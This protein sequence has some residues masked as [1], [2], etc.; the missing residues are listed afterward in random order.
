MIGY[1]PLGIT[2]TLLLAMLLAS[3]Y[4][5]IGLK[6]QDGQI[7]C[8][9]EVRSRSIIPRHDFAPPLSSTRVP[10]LLHSPVYAPLALALSVLQNVMALRSGA[11][12]APQDIA[13]LLRR[14]ESVSAWVPCQHNGSGGG[15]PGCAGYAAVVRSNEDATAA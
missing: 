8:K 9:L 10:P 7:L 6:I 14:S 15:S 5:C 12:A 3:M 2:D 1:V 11:I 13:D 4:H